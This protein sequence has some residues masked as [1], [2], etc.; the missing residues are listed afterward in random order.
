MRLK[1]FP[2]IMEE[3][4]MRVHKMVSKS[5]GYEEWFVNNDLYCGKRLTV[6]KDQY[7]SKGK[8]HY[9]KIK[10]ETFF[11]IKGTLRIELDI[12]PPKILNEGDSYRI[13]PNQYHRFT[14][15]TDECKFI[16]VS[17]THSDD[18]SYRVN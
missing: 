11:V 1:D 16:E 15:E 7:S 5:W 9:H 17:T 2:T 3:F 8:F 6:F 4:E 18:D 14:S 13:K 12:G 10:D